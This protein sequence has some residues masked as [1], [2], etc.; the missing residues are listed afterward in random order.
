MNCVLRHYFDFF[1]IVFIDGILVYSSSHEQH[2]QH[3]RLYIK[4]CRIIGCMPNSPSVSVV[5][6]LWNSGAH[7]IQGLDYNRPAQDRIAIWDWNRPSSP[8]EVQFY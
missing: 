6:S 7:G 3:L 1:V 5:L 4:P 2:K 8:T